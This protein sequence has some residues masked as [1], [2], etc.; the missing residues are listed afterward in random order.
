MEYKL[1]L[2]GVGG[3]GILS[4]AKIIAMAAMN[5]GLQICQTEVHGMS[6]RGGSVSASVQISDHPIFSPLIEQGMADLVV[7]M[8]PMEGV[9]YLQFLKS[10][11]ILISDKEPIKNFS[12]YPS[13]KMLYKKIK[14]RPS[15]RLIK[16]KGLARKYKL[17]DAEN[18]LLLGAVSPFLPISKK[19]FIKAI[20]EF[21]SSKVGCVIETNI[22]A[23]MVGVGI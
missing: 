9:R 19:A 11:G 8:E 7:G 20:R 3:Q 6:Q 13:L 17:S 12:K 4:V 2:S 16:I 5:D 22:R 10:D 14:E 18:I 21:F 1:I 23:Y 15:F